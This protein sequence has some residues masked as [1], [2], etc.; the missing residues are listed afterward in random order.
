MSPQTKT[1]LT[2]PEVARRLGVSRSHAY[3]TVIAKGLVPVIRIGRA[4][5][6]RPEDV[7]ALIDRLADEAVEP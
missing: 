4:V 2:I 3:E 5:R 1:L 7:D 6:V